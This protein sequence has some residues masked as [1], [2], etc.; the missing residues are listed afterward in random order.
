MTR[1]KLKIAMPQEM[2]LRVTSYLYPTIS[3]DTQFTFSWSHAFY[4]H[5]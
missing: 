2:A 4:W 5:Y 1:K 3:H